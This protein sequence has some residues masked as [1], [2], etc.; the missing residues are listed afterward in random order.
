M[1]TNNMSDRSSIKWETATSKNGASFRI[2]REKTDVKNEAP[3]AGKA[4]SIHVDWPVGDAWVNTTDEVRTTA[5]ITQYYLSANPIQ[6]VWGYGLQFTN[7]DTYDYFFYDETGDC[8]EVD[9]WLTH[10]HFV[11]YNSDKPTI[12]CI[13]GR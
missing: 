9:T 10:T 8:Y 11:Q 1:Y 12:V 2:G 5:A 4:F 13:T 3:A 7:T 6:S